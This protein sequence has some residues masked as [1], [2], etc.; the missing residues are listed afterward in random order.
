MQ[1]DHRKDHLTWQP[2]WSRT[3]HIQA[4]DQRFQN[5]LDAWNYVLSHP[6]CDYH[7]NLF[8]DKWSQFDWTV[9]PTPSIQEI[10]RKRC[11]DLR[12][13]YDWIRLWYS[14]GRDSDLILQ[15][16][17]E[18]GI[19]IDEI[20]TWYNPND[21]LRGPE[22][23]YI[24]QPL[25]GKLRKILPHTKF[26]VFEFTLKDY[27]DYFGSEKW[28]ERKIGGPSAGYYF[29]PAQMSSQVAT[30]PDLFPQR[31]QG[32][33]DVNLYGIDKPKL[34]LRDNKFYLQHDHLQSQMF[35]G[36]GDWS[37][38]FYWHCD[39]PEIHAKQT[40]NLI[41]HLETHYPSLTN[42]FVGQYSSGKLGAY[43]YDE[44]CNVLG[45]KES[46][47]W[48]IGLGENKT[49]AKNSRWQKLQDWGEKTKWKPWLN[50][51]NMIATLRNELPE[52]FN[53]G[54]PLKFHIG[55]MSRPIYIKDYDPS[56]Y[57]PKIAV[58]NKL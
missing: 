53:Q 29:F 2:D 46:A 27:E 3:L 4:G 1:L 36:D 15:T 32:L 10:Y 44:L 21:N 41:N 33:K 48:Y 13:R 34:F 7:F 55:F 18:N 25:M 51:K 20:V 37:E 30:R 47:H 42:D 16:F 28:I 12:N 17:L 11:E 8:T 31:Q 43:K 39:M 40:W 19:K 49:P 14:G 54:D 57:D 35:W 26:T 5:D 23:Y 58:D 50:Y 56:R 6:G 38:F 24:V 45:R 22:N 9:E 52:A